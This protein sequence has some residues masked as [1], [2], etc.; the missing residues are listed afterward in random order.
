MSAFK[1]KVVKTASGKEYVLQ[2]PGVRA[3]TK[4]SDR[5]K[6]KH[7]VIMDER[8]CDEMLQHIVVEPKTTLE[9]FDSYPEM[10]DVVRRAFAFISGQEDELEHD[11]QQAGS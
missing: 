9:S 1:Q 5:I 10:I 7:G 3:V 2:H 8:L 4:I 6:N 11:D